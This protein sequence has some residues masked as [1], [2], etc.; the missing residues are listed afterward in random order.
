MISEISRLKET[1]KQ[2]ENNYKK[3]SLS[4]NASHLALQNINQDLTNQLI[5]SENEN[6]KI[7]E[8]IEPKNMQI[9]KLLEISHSSSSSAAEIRHLNEKNIRLEVENEKLVALN[10]D[11]QYL[12]PSNQNLETQL[13]IAQVAYNNQYELNESNNQI[14]LTH[15]QNETSLISE[16]TRL[17]DAIK[18]AEGDLKK[19][20][21]SSNAS[22]L[23]IQN[24]N[25]DLKNKLNELSEKNKNLVSQIEIKNNQLAQF[26]ENSSNEISIPSKH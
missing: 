22:N 9:N 26:A 3:N 13:S 19:N 1:I 6:K 8:Q 12:I 7:L 2:M 24:I 18:Q 14:I 23:T 4:A 16:I 25:Q 20:S 21:V 11:A 17:K 10:Q 15:Q 5:A